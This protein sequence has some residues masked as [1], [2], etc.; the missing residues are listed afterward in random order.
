MSSDTITQPTS[1]NS[2]EIR[3]FRIE[4]PQADLDYLRARLANARWV[5]DEVSDGGWDYGVPVE[6]LREL[7]SYWATEYDWRAH[8]AKMNAHP[9]FITEIDGVDIHF[10]H[11][12]SSR[13]DAFPLILTHGWPGTF[14]EYLPVIEQLTEP[15]AGEQ[16]FHL[17][18][19]S[20]PGFGFSGPTREKGWDIARVAAAWITLMDRLG[21]ER[22][23]AAGSDGGS[24]VSPVMGA[25]APEAV[26]AVHVTQVFSYPSGDPTEF[27]G[28]GPDEYRRLAFMQRFEKEHS[29]FNKIQSTRPLTL[30]HA[31]ADSP[32]GQLAWVL[33]PIRG[34]GDHPPEQ[35]E[36]LDADFALTVASLH[37]LSGNAGT[38][39]RF[40]YEEAHKPEAETPRGTVPTGVAVFASDFPSIRSLA[41]RDHNIVHWAEF[42]RGGHYSGTD[43]PDL[44]AGDL[45]T[46]FG[47]HQ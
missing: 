20:M 22:Y 47:S 16:A 27:E 38:L 24:M 42:D 2:T 3:P 28:F 5:S 30:A 39:T 19:P 32:V 17:V 8:E 12:R 21:Y 45:R 34:F 15:A 9:Q 36:A 11:I 26:A 10:L 35:D 23:G 14:Y 37:W 33:D 18:I 43:A 13:P 29:G 40:H 6:R 4:I 31:L 44:L 7:V 41:E 25:M 46:F 1:T